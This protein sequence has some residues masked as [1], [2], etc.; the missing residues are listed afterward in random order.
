MRL[1]K[2][3]KPHHII[4]SLDPNES[5]N[6]N[7]LGIISAETHKAKEAKLGTRHC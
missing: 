4:Q 7:N 1:N 6:N 3:K 2:K 5:H